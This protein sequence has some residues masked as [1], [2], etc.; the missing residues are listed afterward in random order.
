MSTT[1]LQHHPMGP[2]GLYRREA[3]PASLRLEQGQPDM[4]SE[5]ADAGTDLHAIVA[6]ALA[7]KG[8]FFAEPDQEEAVRWALNLVAEVEAR[9]PG[10]ERRIECRLSLEHIGCGFGTTDLAY[11]IPF[12]RGVVLDWKFGWGDVAPAASNIQ[13]HAYALALAHEFDLSSVEVILA[14]PIR[15][16]ASV[17]ILAAGGLEAARARIVSIAA[18]C[19]EASAQPI[20]GDHCKYCKA[21]AVCP[22][23][24]ATASS[25]ATMEKPATDLTADDLA[26]LL[27]V[28]ERAVEVAGAIKARAYALAVQGVAIPGYA[29]VPGRATRKWLQ[30]ADLAAVAKVLGKPEGEIYQPIEL[31]SPAQLESEWG[32][33]KKVREAMAP[34]IE[35]V[36]GKE[37]LKRVE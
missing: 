19:D 6:D 18:K 30:G 37:Q 13:L 12:D 29:L 20:P 31:R 34:L 11:A 32:K 16:Q 9:Y 7:H 25:L 23:M 8:E 1:E 21:K 27:P 2:S 15:R 14:Q 4:P 28:A 22:A 36:A 10:A 26:K 24:Q 33:S 5:D 35:S 3:C 17:H